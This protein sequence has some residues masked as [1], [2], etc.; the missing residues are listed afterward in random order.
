MDSDNLRGLRRIQRFDLSRSLNALAANDQVILAAELSADA[1]DG[2]AH[3]ARALFLA[4][5]VK[6]L[7]DE[8][9]LMGGCARPDGEFQGG[10]GGNPFENCFFKLSRCLKYF[11]P[12]TAGRRAPESFARGL[13]CHL[14]RGIGSQRFGSARAAPATSS[15]ATPTASR[16]LTR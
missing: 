15:R 12:R 2:G 4:E 9:A 3:L 1:F 10:H 11:T 13:A 7:V 16:S 5:I 8:G 6:R 14:V